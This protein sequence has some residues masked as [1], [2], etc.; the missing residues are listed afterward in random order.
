MKK[1][2]FLIIGLFFLQIGRAQFDDELSHTQLYDKAVD[3][4]VYVQMLA[5]DKL[6]LINN[7]HKEQAAKELDY[8]LAKLSENINDIDLNNED[9]AVKDLMKNIKKIWQNLNQKAT[10]NI[11]NKE[12]TALYFQANTFEHLVDTMVEKMK[13]NYQL[14]ADKIQNYNDIQTLRILI[15][16]ITISY[17][18]NYLGLSKSYLHE[19]QKNIK[20]VDDF[21][22]RNSNKFLNDPVSGKIFSDIIIDWNFFRANILHTDQKNPKTVFSLSTTMD[23]KLRVIKDKYIETLNSD[24]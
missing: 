21:I 15:E 24:F 5:K 13:V 11:S 20:N 3:I 6:Y 8:A 10:Q 19:Y 1:A 17:Y 12:F 7:T 18:A 16:K 23:Y 2:F 22:K 9:Q 14:P 4:K